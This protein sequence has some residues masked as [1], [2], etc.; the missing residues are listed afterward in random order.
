VALPRDLVDEV[1]RLDEGQLRQL[2]ILARGLLLTSEQPVIEISDVAGM[3][4][5]RYRQR[6]VRCGKAACTTCPHG[7]YWY[8]H[9]TEDGRRRSRYIG[10]ELPAE[11]RRKLDEL[12]DIRRTHV[13]AGTDVAVAASAGGGSGPSPARRGLRLVGD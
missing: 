12:D 9:W 8:A 3:P 10:A 13:P 6:S 5:V 1:R 7:P 4:T 2:M 11:V